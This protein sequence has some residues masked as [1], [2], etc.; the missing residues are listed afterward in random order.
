MAPRMKDC[1]DWCRQAYVHRARLECLPFEGGGDRQKVVLALPGVR[2]VPDYYKPLVANPRISR[3][4]DVTDVLHA[5]DIRSHPIGEAIAKLMR[6]GRKTPDPTHDLVKA[7][8]HI[9]RALEQIDM[10]KERS[11]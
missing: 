6:A 1:F 8:E 10:A 4:A 2:F 7:I 9:Q 3:E 5:F 11:E